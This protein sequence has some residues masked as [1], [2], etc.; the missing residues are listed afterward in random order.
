MHY[1]H[2]LKKAWHSKQVQIFKHNAVLGKNSMPSS[3]SDKEIETEE[4]LKQFENINPDS[5]S[6]QKH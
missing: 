1:T 2:I 4:A 3:G 6:K 5:L